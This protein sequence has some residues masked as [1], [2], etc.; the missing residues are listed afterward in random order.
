[1]PV[2]AP[3]LN[4]TSSADALGGSLRGAHVGA[5]RH[6]HADETAS[7]RQHG[8]QHEADSRAA[9]QEGVDQ[10]GQHH[11]DDTDGLV[12]AGQ[13]GGCA[14][15]DGRSNFL[16]AGIARVLTQNPAALDEPVKHGSKTAR[17]RH[18]KRHIGGYQ[19]ISFLATS[20][21]MDA[22][23]LCFAWSIVKIHRAGVAKPM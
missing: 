22:P 17:Q 19:D 6:V 11:A 10:H 1:M 12:L 20:P 4:A 3:P 7:A 14:L 15:L 13:V 2:M 16:H 21:V 8:A 23:P 18:I 9:A 5:H